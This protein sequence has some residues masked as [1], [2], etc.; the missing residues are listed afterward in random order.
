[1]K[2]TTPTYCLTGCLLVAIAASSQTAGAQFIWSGASGSD[3]NWLT[4]GNWSPSD[5]PGATDD[6]RLFDNGATNDV[7]SMDNL[8]A[9]DMTVK[10]L[11]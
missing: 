5:P 7:I 9:A 2:H 1:M 6:T 3:L 8:V 4:P 11:G 10:S